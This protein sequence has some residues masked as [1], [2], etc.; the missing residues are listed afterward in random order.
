VAELHRR[1]GR[2]PQEINAWVNRAVGL[3]RVEQASIEQLERSIETLTRE[4]MRVSRR[5]AAS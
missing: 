1:D 4:L 3:E 2:S 5:R